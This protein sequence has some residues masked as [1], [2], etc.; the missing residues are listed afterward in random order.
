M[1]P[2]LLYISNMIQ[3]QL[4]TFLTRLDRGKMIGRFNRH[5]ER[6]AEEYLQANEENIIKRKVDRIRLK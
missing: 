3:S 5:S 2:L 4:I 1:G 6:K